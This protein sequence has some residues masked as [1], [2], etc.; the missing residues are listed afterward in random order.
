MSRKSFNARSAVAGS[1]LAMAASSAHAVQKPYVGNFTDNT[2][3]VI[4]NLHRTHHPPPSRGLRWSAR[5]AISQDGTRSMSQAT[6]PRRC[7]VTTRR[8]T[9]SPRRSTW[10]RSPTGITLTPDGKLLLVTLYGEDR[11]R[12]RYRTNDVVGRLSTAP[13]KRSPVRSA[14]CSKRR[15]ARSRTCRRS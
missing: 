5:M 13:A 2:V 9:A 7:N 4:D 8:P 14:R 12:C 10:A 11:M 15:S 3:S 6:G 1:M